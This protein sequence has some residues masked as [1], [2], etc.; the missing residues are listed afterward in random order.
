MKNEKVKLINDFLAL[1]PETLGV[2]GY[3]SGITKQAGYTNGDKPQTDLILAVSNTKEWHLQNIEMNP[4]D[5]SFTGKQ[6][7][8]RAPLSWYSIGADICYISNIKHNNQTYKVGIINKEDLIEDLLHWKTFYLAGRFQ[9][10]ILKVKS[11]YDIDAA[12]ETNRRNALVLAL[13]L[14]DE[15]ATVKDLYANIC[16]LSYIGDTRMGIAENPNKVNNIVEG[17][18]DALDSMYSTYDLF[19]IDSRTGNIYYDYL[20]LLDNIEFLPLD[21]NPLDLLIYDKEEL[22]AMKRNI[23][24]QLKIK[25]RNA[26]IGQTFKGLLTAGPGRSAN[27]AYQKIKKHFTK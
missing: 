27:Y 21:I 4:S 14:S 10:P 18:F 1:R 25:N 8:T 15:Q 24:H 2:Y 3:G 17:G 5:Y 26:S 6:F 16:R 22:I 9:K 13:L 7:F 19:A 20:D 11:E 12:I 23:E